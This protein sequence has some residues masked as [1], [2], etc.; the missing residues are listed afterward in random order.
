MDHIEETSQSR[1]NAKSNIRPGIIDK[2]LKHA[3]KAKEKDKNLNMTKKQE[4]YGQTTL[5]YKCEAWIKGNS[6]KRQSSIDFIATRPK[7]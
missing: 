1:I 5:N 6:K 2:N 3:C 7:E 4:E